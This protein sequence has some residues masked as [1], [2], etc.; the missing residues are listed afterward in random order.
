MIEYSLFETLMFAVGLE[1]R[2]GLPILVEGPPGTTKSMGSKA[3]CYDL[4]LEPIVVMLSLR[5]STEVAGLPFLDNEGD[6][7]VIKPPRWAKRAL[8]KKHVCVIFDEF[9]TAM[10]STHDAALRVIQ[11]GCL[12]DLVLPKSMRSIA[13]QNPI[14]QTG[15][16]NE[17]SL[18]MVNRFGHFHVP[19]DDVIGFGSY[20]MG[21][22]D[23]TVRD[24]EADTSKA[25]AHEERIRK[26][27]PSK[28]TPNA[29]L[30]ASYLKKH[31]DQ[32]RITPNLITGGTEAEV[33]AYPTKRSWEMLTRAMTSAD[34]HQLPEQLSIQLSEAFIGV[35]AAK[36]F[37]TYRLELDLPD[38]EQL[39]DGKIRWAHD[40]RRP[41]RTRVTL[42]ACA[43]TVRRDGNKNKLAV[44]RAKTLWGLLE[45]VVDEA[46]DLCIDSMQILYMYGFFL[47][48][49]NNKVM[50]KM[51]PM[52]KAAGV[53]V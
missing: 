47:D 41:D 44:S 43:E 53:T 5:Q 27:W 3:Y 1:N 10:R 31:P 33:R 19:P 51:L 49:R 40:P 18:A 34:L 11:E 8:A 22:A 45:K 25:A 9:N 26:A 30:V 39:L 38:P 52:L 48:D 6:D 12:D 20:L 16:G 14:S 42:S 21:C 32:I 29:T 28:W 13:L 17:L 50:E 36:E 7:V 2:M 15:A 23:A 24:R 4:G 35:S 46:Q 37:L